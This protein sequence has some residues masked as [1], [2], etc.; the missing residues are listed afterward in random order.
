M[1]LYYHIFPTD[2]P[3]FKFYLKPVMEK[4]L[5]IR[6]GFPCEGIRFILTR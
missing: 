6:V 5:R 2:T 4:R 3:R 1:F